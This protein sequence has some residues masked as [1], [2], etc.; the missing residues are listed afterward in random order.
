MIG[1]DHLHIGKKDAVAD[2]LAA[3]LSS[4]RSGAITIN[5]EEM[6]A[7]RITAGISGISVDL[8]PP[9]AFRM[10]EDTG[11]F[12]KLKTASEFG[13]KLSDRGVTL[14]FSRQGKEAVRLGKNARP[15]LSKLV[16]KSDD[17]QVSSLRQL[18]RLKGDLKD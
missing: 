13:R 10:H 2:W 16:S 14:S 15:T 12:D 9:R 8:L 18:A 1:D 17:V 4:A 5:F 7:A 3:A 11:L 6:P